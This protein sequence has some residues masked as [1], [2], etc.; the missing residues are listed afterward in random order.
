MCAG[1]RASMCTGVRAS[2]CTGMRAS[3]CT[4]VRA[5]MCTG[6]R[7][8]QLMRADD[9]VV[10]YNSGFHLSARAGSA[11]VPMSVAPQ[12]AHSDDQVGLCPR[13]YLSKFIMPSMMT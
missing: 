12:G 4:G 9:A 5:S 13:R 6:V 2:M 10:T 11:R 3:M 1:V 7:R 8:F